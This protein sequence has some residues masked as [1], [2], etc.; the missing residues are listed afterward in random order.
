MKN[1]SKRSRA[2]LVGL[3][4][5]SLA[6]LAA[7]GS[8]E[9]QAADGSSSGDGD[10]TIAF[11]PLA[12]KI[13]AMKGLSEGGTQYGKSKGYEVLVQDPNLDPQKQVTDLQSVIESGRV[14][15]AWAI[16][17]DASSMKALVAK[18]QKD[19][20]PLI[21]NGTPELYGFD[22][23]QP[24]LSFSTIDYV[25]QGKAIGEELGNCINEKLDGKAEV[26]MEE[27]APGTAGKEEIETAAKEALAATAPGAKIVTS[28][29][30]NDR[31]AAQTDVGNALQGNPDVQAVLG[32]NDE[33]ALGAIGGFKA[34]G[35]KLVCLT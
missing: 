25:A 5:G 35:K 31:A 12:L 20:V 2:A 19:E 15:G 11:S 1:P 28:V 32:N 29:V 9:T 22:G 34:A 8:G 21:L 17:I 14:A 33:G 10:K 4:A 30:V 27:N 13:P 24:G 6:L 16:S 7:C 26:I 18:A 3:T 23:P